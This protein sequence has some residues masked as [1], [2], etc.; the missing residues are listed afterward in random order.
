MLSPYL[1][2]LNLADEM[3]SKQTIGKKVNF[4]VTKYNT[5]SASSIPKWE[6]WVLAESF[7]RYEPTSLLQRS[8]CFSLTATCRTLTVVLLVDLLFDMSSCFPVYGSLIDLVSLP[9]PKALWE[10]STEAEWERQYI[11]MCEREDDKKFQTY[12][13]LMRDHRVEGA[14]DKWLSQLDSLGTVV[15]AAASL[16]PPSIDD[17]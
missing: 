1:P 14:F 9:C 15:M 5:P 10:A 12:A 17:I 13:D 16:Q 7:R 11:A 3:I 8:I 6:D 4:L 2:F